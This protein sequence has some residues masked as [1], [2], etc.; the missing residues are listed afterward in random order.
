M[1]QLFRQLYI[2]VC[3]RQKCLFFRIFSLHILFSPMFSG[4][5]KSDNVLTSVS[6]KLQASQLQLGLK[7]GS[8]RKKYPDAKCTPDEVK[9]N[10]WSG[11]QTSV[12]RKF[13]RKFHGVANVVNHR[14]L[15]VFVI[16]GPFRKK[17]VDFLSR[18]V[19][20]MTS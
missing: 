11:A 12:F 6:S 16:Q 13:S 15:D 17:A 2:N 1:V 14:S 4:L 18:K 10:L 8:L 9:H 20:I 5:E 19:G 3:Q 7:P